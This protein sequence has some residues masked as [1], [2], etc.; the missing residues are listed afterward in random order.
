VIFSEDASAFA[1]TLA[2]RL[3]QRRAEARKFLESMLAG[4]LADHIEPALDVTLES[5]EPLGKVLESSFTKEGSAELAEWLSLK[6]AEEPYVLVWPLQELALLATRRFLDTYRTRFPSPAPR[7]Q[8]FIADLLHSLGRRLVLLGRATEAVPYL[9]DSLS[10]YQGLG[11]EKTSARIQCLGNLSEGLT[12]LGRFPDALSIAE[13]AVAAIQTEASGAGVEPARDVQLRL[14]GQLINLCGCLADVDRHGDA[15]AAINESVALY[16]RCGW[17]GQAQAYARALLCQGNELHHR[18]LY[19]E[20]VQSLEEAILLSRELETERATAFEPDLALA[21][22]DLS[23]LYEQIGRFEDANRTLSE[24]VERFRRLE[25]HYADSFRPSVAWSL[26]LLSPEGR[27]ETT[28][29]AA[30]QEAVE[31]YRRLAASQPGIYEPLLGKSLFDLSESLLA[32]GERKAALVASNEAVARLRQ[33]SSNRRDLAWSLLLRGRARGALGYRKKALADCREA[34][35]LFRR[36]SAWQAAFYDVDLA[37]ALHMLSIHLHYL[38]RFKEA[39]AVTQEAVAIYRRLAASAP[40]A[41]TEDLASCLNSLS[42]HL[43]EDGRWEESVAASRESVELY[44]K[45]VDQLPN[46][47]AGL[48]ACLSNLPPRLS[49]LDRLDEALEAASEALEL[50]R[51]NRFNPEGLAAVLH[52][53]GTV[54]L[55][56][57]KPEEAL[58]HLREAVAIRRRLAI[59]EPK[60]HDVDLACSLVTLGKSLS[61]QHRYREALPETRRGIRLLRG[62]VKQGDGFLEPRLAAALSNQAHQL[63]KLGEPR[64]ALKAAEEA[65]QL[66]TPFFIDSPSQYTHWTALALRHYWAAAEEAGIEP[67]LTKIAKVIAV[68]ARENE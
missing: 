64:A 37:V 55:D 4:R 58:P 23:L 68:F 54:L 24:A 3:A 28:S 17:H 35:V 26:S 15:L 33:S 43:Y 47:V 59:D 52:S 34:V 22:A 10:T 27:N 5:G 57:Q 39:I 49:E 11:P 48:A 30:R 16:R 44:R 20:A 29:V 63:R 45:I 6:L 32:L 56:L 14:A 65:V 19:L 25:D 40:P 13:E 61:A 42:H 36:R 38:G 18:S 1:L 9:R 8:A 12:Q 67:D 60:I 46:A 2:T 41:L 7:E 31:R 66:L 62:T 50:F 51:Q 53:L 21:L